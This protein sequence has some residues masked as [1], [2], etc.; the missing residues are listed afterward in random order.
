MD[1]AFG[2]HSIVRSRMAVETFALALKAVHEFSTQ[3]HCSDPDDCGKENF[4]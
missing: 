1:G 2:G 3:L 4:S